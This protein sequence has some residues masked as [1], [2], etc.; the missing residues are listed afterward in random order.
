[1]SSLMY[2]VLS[3]NTFIKDNR[4][5]LAITY[6][7]ICMYVQVHLYRRRE[8]RT[9]T[10]LED[11]EQVR[12]FYVQHFRD[13]NI[14]WHTKYQFDYDMYLIFFKH[15]SCVGY[16]LIVLNRIIISEISTNYYIDLIC[17]SQ[18]QINCLW[19]I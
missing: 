3:L 1:M 5:I 8:S 10:S 18:D 17:Y 2:L 4:I 11:C 19:I 16:N 15:L 12:I 14:K 7:C 6:L 9:V 13:P